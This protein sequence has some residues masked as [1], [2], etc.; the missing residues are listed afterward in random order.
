MQMLR[1]GLA[2]IVRWELL[3]VALLAPLLLFPGR[4]GGL[5]MAGVPLLWGLR[6]LD[7]RH[8]VRRTPL[9]WSICLLL[10][11]VLVS[12]LITFDLNLSLPKIT[13]VVLGVACYYGLAARLEQPRTI[14][15]G[16]IFLLIFGCGVAC[17]SLVGTSWFNKIPVLGRVAMLLPVAIRGLPGSPPEG[18]HPNQVA[19]ALIW[20]LPLMFILFWRYRSRDLPLLPPGWQWP[21]KQ[22]FLLSLL[23]VGGTMVLTQSR[24]GYIGLF[25][26]TMA[27]FVLPR[28]R[29]L[30]GAGALIA[31]GII[32]AI[33]V[34][35]QTFIAYNQI[36]SF[37]SS[38][39]LNTVTLEGRFEVWSRAIYAIQDF[40]FTGVG[41][42]AF[43]RVMPVLYPLF[44]AAPDFDVG[45]AHNHILNAALDLGIPGLIAYLALWL[46]TALMARQALRTTTD[47][48]LATLTLGLSGGMVAFFT[49]S[50]TDTQGLGS[51]PN[52]LMWLVFGLIFCLY[53]AAGVHATAPQTERSA[54]DVRP[55]GA[56][57]PEAKA[58]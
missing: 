22:L 49:Y 36:E 29:L 38:S 31:V 54:G 45:H 4:V 34:G 57:V 12:L 46:G 17:I 1:S 32:A 3:F 8:F 23:L 10:V 43:R 39:A 24:S 11:M 53:Q 40:P 7:Q 51:K 30:L 19:G 52:L 26:G 2:W 18:F 58:G 27:L 50:F 13:G 14:W 41:I 42:G 56:P 55:S 20:V 25:C 44:S 15:L 37:Q 16:V 33:V 9:D 47:D 28:R 5:A 21:M 6:W 35:P 48:G